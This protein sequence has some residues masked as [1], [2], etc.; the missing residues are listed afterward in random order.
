MAYNLIFTFW[1]TKVTQSFVIICNRCTFTDHLQELGHKENSSF[2]TDK[3]LLVSRS[4]A[5]KML[6]NSN[7]HLVSIDMPVSSN[8][9]DASGLCLRFSGEILS[10]SKPCLITVV[11][12]GKVSEPLDVTVKVNCEDTMFGLNLLN[13][14]VAF[15]HWNSL[16]F[17]SSL[18]L[19]RI[20]LLILSQMYTLHI[21]VWILNILLLVQIQE[22][23]LIIFFF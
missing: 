7:L 19:R 12:E 14:V 3:I 9:D 16:L 18:M 22:L 11:V 17:P 8:I 5:S 23:V 1:K 2:Q 15:L 20:F 21:Y 13:R 6:S 4:F 10:S